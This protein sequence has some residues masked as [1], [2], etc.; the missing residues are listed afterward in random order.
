MHKILVV[1][2]SSIGDIVLTTPVI[3]AL[4]TQLHFS[5]IHYLTK[6]TYHEVLIAN[7]YIDKIHLL[8]EGLSKNIPTLKEENFECVIDLHNNLRT[9]K[10]KTRLGIKTFTLDKINFDK[11]MMTA[12]KINNLP[13]KHIVD[14]YFE[15]VA[16]LKVKNDNKGLDYFIPKKDE[17]KINTLPETHRNGYIGFVL[18]ALF[19]TKQFPIDKV[20]RSE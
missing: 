8:D 4:K 16:E 6:K 10:V 14:R 15:T 5:E 11:W 1:R 2:F 20:I 18:G 19:N 12:F 9:L 3:R 17:V 13:D 7:P